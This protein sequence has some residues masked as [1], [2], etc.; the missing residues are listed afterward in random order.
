M[1]CPHKVRNTKGFCA[2]GISSH[3]SP[4]THSLPMLN[5]CKVRNTKGVCANMI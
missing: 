1:R 3:N 4:N 2:N 5:P